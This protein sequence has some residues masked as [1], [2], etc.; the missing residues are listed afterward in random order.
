MR[1]VVGGA[2]SGLERSALVGRT[3]CTAPLATPCECP[4]SGRHLTS[5]RQENRAD[6]W[7]HK[8]SPKSVATGWPQEEKQDMERTIRDLQTEKEIQAGGEI[9]E[10]Q[11]QVDTLA[12]E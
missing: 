9:R 11:A 6:I 12:L 7:K 5:I 1:V 4:G 2:V 10:L 8:K 3:S